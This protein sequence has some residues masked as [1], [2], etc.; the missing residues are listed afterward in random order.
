MAKII[1]KKLFGWRTKEEKNLQLKKKKNVQNKHTSK[2]YHYKAYK[3]ITHKTQWDK[4][5]LTNDIH[6]WQY[7]LGLL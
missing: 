3:Q 5:W 1:K 4:K 7:W 6:Q 2:T